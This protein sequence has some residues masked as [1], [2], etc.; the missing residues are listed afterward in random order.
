MIQDKKSV[1]LFGNTGNKKIKI[2]VSIDPEK[3]KGR[4][5]MKVITLCGSTKF[6]TEFE[7][8]M[9][10]ET[11]K[12]NI[13]IS[14]GFFGHQTGLDM[15]SET[16]RMLDKIHFRKIDMSDE[17]YVINPGGYIG[18]STCD[19]IHYA[20]A[21][22]KSINWLE[23]PSGWKDPLQRNGYC[24]DCEYAIKY[25]SG[26]FR[27]RGYKKPCLTCKRPEM[28]NFKKRKAIK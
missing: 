19:E 11:L 25:P 27:E 1:Y 14:V 2:G 23:I 12:G 13:V 8:V 17:I 24:R 16:K 20:I 7:R 10:E 15:N 18:L 21:S 5:K 22:R 4:L 9:A 26:I 6:K 3:A 28:S